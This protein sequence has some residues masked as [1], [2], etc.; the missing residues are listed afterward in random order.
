MKPWSSLKCVKIHDD[1]WERAEWYSVEI[2]NQ[3]VSYHSGC[4]PLIME[5]SVLKKQFK[6]MLSRRWDEM[7][8]E[9]DIGI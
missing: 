8:D 6:S 1:L 3:A 5:D 2:I 4:C 9:P 7:A